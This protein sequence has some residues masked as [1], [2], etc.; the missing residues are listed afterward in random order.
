MLTKDFWH[1]EGL[2][3]E[4]AGQTEAHGNR[5][6][7]MLE[8]YVCSYHNKVYC[9]WAGCHVCFVLRQLTVAARC[10]TVTNSLSLQHYYYLNFWH[11]I[12]SNKNENK[13]PNYPSCVF[14][15]YLCTCTCIHNGIYAHLPVGVFSNL[16]HYQLGI[17]N[18][19]LWRVVEGCI[20]TP[21]LLVATHGK[22]FDIEHIFRCWVPALLNEIESSL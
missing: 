17:L 8:V 6:V 7:F 12:Y 21:G 9:L 15:T 1:S 4:E 2:G 10:A 11:F 19:C 20:V 22:G 18:V 3:A 13:Y 5:V 14:Y 16:R